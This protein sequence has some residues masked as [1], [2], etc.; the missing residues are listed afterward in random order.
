MTAGVIVVNQ[1]ALQLHSGGSL[2]SRLGMEIFVQHF[3]L[4]VRGLVRAPGFAIAATL[5]LAV[6]IGLST[7]VFTVADALLLRHLPVSGQDRLVLLWG[8]TRDGRFANFP[9]ALGDVRDFQRRSRSLGD[10]AFFA[11]RG[12][13]PRR[14]ALTTASTRFKSLSFLATSSTFSAAGPRSA[15]LCDPTTTS[16]AQRPFSS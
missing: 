7:A 4:A 5:T 14:Y 12:P 2:T 6:G 13:R 8:E 3:R 10:V 1:S 9:L 15:V 16:P 11:F